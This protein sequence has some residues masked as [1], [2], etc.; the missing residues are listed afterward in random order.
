MRDFFVISRWRQICPSPLPVPPRFSTLQKMPVTRKLTS[1]R[2]S[3]T[4]W[5]NSA[6]DNARV[7]VQHVDEQ[8]ACESLFSDLPE[9]TVFGLEVEVFDNRAYAHCGQRRQSTVVTELVR[10]E[11]PSGAMH[12]LPHGLQTVYHP[13]SPVS[14]VLR[15]SW[16]NHYASGLLH[17]AS[18]HYWANGSLRAA[19]FYHN[20]RLVGH[21]S[22]Y[23][24]HKTM[25]AVYL[26]V[27]LLHPQLRLP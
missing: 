15:A 8:P 3:F 25:L 13:P 11:L 2:L 7:L 14:G 9:L 23:D 27:Q 17:G 6:H 19:Y 24:E 4:D 22:F 10:V 18:M 1:Q 20:G 16:K 21:Q 26:V 5:F 12:Y